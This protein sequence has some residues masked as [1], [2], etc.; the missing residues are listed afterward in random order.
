MKIAL[1]SEHASP[2]AV[3]GTGSAGGRHV[4]LAGLAKAL[5]N[6]G[7][8]VEIYTRRDA[9]QLPARFELAPG[10]TVVH[11]TA[12]GA[13]PASED[14]RSRA[15]PA[16]GRRLIRDWSTGSPPDIVHAHRWR[17]GA[18]AVIA[19]RS[20]GVP[21]VQSF[22]GL[23]N[24]NGRCPAE[25]P[26]T[27]ADLLQAVDHVVATRADEV[28]EL[29]ARGLRQSDLTLAT[30]G[31]DTERF[32]PDGE[33]WPRGPHR[34]LLFLGRLT[35][36]KGIDTVVRALPGIPDAELLV[37]GGP[38]A[39]GVRIDGE[40]Q[41][42]TRLAGELGVGGRFQLTGSI[43]HEAVPALL[44]SADV[45]V[46]TPRHQPARLA[47]LEAMSC[48]RPV[49]CSDLDG[50]SG[51][52]DGATGLVVRPDDPVAVGA[53]VRRFFADTGF[54]TRVGAAG[55]RV[56]SSYDWKQ[57]A[58]CV[59]DAYEQAARRRSVAAAG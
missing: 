50:T 38:P 55:R 23:A 46:S 4:Y 51:I 7:H 32:A 57:V 58:A 29:T 28:A 39:A 53:A 22:H 30:G 24:G 36:C 13:R 27:E 34:R 15:V 31:V 37:A 59:E 14:E 12:G 6:R 56:A 54:A 9:W 33:A 35:E 19:A 16:F 42:L 25:Q 1:I 3:L 41:R 52:D 44:R 20:V 11:V 8:E 43:K 21:V 10:V 49:V 5:A 48:A 26:P 40:A 18:A 17:S 2:L 45:V 47:P